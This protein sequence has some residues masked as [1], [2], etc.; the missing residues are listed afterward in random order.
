[1]QSIFYPQRNCNN[2][3]R[4]SNICLFSEWIQC[5]TALAEYF[6]HFIIGQE[7]FWEMLN[8]YNQYNNRRGNSILSLKAAILQKQS[9]FSFQTI[10]L[11]FSLH[12]LP[13][14]FYLSQLMRS[15]KTAVQ[16]TLNAFSCI[17]K[18][19]CHEGLVSPFILQF[20]FQQ[21]RKGRPSLASLLLRK[22]IVL[23]PILQS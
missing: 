15:P 22:K 17:I 16:S 8:P 12:S 1:M 6:L 4:V 19:V 11:V 10:P 20:I 23:P 13:N 2:F 5:S 14:G 9:Y 18:K 21:L 3:V 7:T